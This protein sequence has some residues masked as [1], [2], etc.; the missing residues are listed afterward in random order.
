ML[1]VKREGKEV[2]MGVGILIKEEKELREG[3][4]EAKR[5]VKEKQVPVLVNV[6]I[7]KSDFREGS[8]SV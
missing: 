5:I 2:V 4:L 3:L 7:S 6:L 8:I 1:K